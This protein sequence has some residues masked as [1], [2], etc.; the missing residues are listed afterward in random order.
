MKDREKEEHDGSWIR[1]SSPLP[2]GKKWSPLAVVVAITIVA[3]VLIALRL[4]VS[5][6]GDLVTGT[7]SDFILDN[8][9]MDADWSPGD[10]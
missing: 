3:L 8:R 1:S 5:G 9:D 4:F 7:A 6:E 2:I 10:V